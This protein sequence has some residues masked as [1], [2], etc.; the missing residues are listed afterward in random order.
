VNGIGKQVPAKNCRCRLKMCRCRPK[1]AGAGP[2]CTSAGL[3]SSAKCRYQPKILLL[4]RFQAF[5]SQ[6]RHL[7]S[8][9]GPA[10]HFDD[11]FMP[12]PA[13]FKRHRHFF[14]YFRPAL[15]LFLNILG[16]HRHFFA[17]ASAFH[18]SLFLWY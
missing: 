4:L 17:G 5:L 7:S 12:A 16:L 9:F 1:I 13:Y 14:E 10:R 8:H 3:K 11:D 2:K 6:H 18:P 15:S